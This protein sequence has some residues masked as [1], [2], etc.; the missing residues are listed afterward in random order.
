ML[1]VGIACNGDDHVY[2][3]AEKCAACTAL[4]GDARKHSEFLALYMRDLNLDLV[5]KQIK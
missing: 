3:E 4:F 5:R 2:S 1:L